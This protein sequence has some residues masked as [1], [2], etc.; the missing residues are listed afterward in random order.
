[1]ADETELAGL[2]R[3]PDFLSTLSTGVHD[4]IKSFTHLMRLLEDET[5]ATVALLALLLGR[6]F[7]PPFWVGGM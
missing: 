7:F 2:V 4:K 5:K 3:G 6:D 1:M